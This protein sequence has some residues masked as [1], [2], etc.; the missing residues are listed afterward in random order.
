MYVYATTYFSIGSVKI[1]H[2]DVEDLVNLVLSIDETKIVL[3]IVKT[4]PIRS[5]F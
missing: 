5:Q 1:D 3:N 2:W 4:L